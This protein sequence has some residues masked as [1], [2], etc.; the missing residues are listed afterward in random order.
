MLVVDI[1]FK[2]LK[3]LKIIAKTP[4]KK[5]LNI[6]ASLK[7]GKHESTKTLMGRRHEIW[8]KGG[9]FPKDMGLPKAHPRL[10]AARVAYEIG[11]VKSMEQTDRR[12]RRN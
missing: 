1:R 9:R 8:R 11:H 3:L 6:D 12:T 10:G 4:W 2:N 7:R 5:S